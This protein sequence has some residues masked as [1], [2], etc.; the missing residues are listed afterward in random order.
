MAAGFV[1]VQPDSTG[2][3]LQTFVNTIGLDSV[4]AE[5]VVLVDSTGAVISPALDSTLTG[6]SAKAIARGGAKG[7][8]TAADVTSTASGANH[9]GADVC[10]YDA[11]G[12]LID[13]R[14]IRALTASDVVTAAQGTAAALSGAWPVK[15]TDGTNAIT[16]KAASTAAAAADTS[17]VV[18]LSPN[19]PLPAGTNTLGKVDQGAAAAAT[20]GWPMKFQNPTTAG[21][22]SGTLNFSVAGDTSAVAGVAAQTV[23]IWRLFFVVAAAVNITLKDGA[24]TNFTG[25][26]TFLAGG[27]LVL[28]FCGEPW[29]VTSAANAFVINC[30]AAV[31]V[32]G[33]VYYTQS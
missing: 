9:Q 26:M 22:T 33:R 16:V 21:L 13:P 20:A 31:Q 2:K 24:A 32:S 6:G 18:A 23:R 15:P 7:T 1:Q 27:A 3:K 19:T 5:G 4:H 14:S 29:F 17:E 30:S 11:A 10:L 25:A 8:T 28:D 12:N